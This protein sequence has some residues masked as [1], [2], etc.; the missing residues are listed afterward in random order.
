MVT[1]MKPEEL[2]FGAPASLTVEGIEVGATVD[3]PKVSVEI[4]E[5]TPDFQGARG[6]VKGTKAI[7]KVLL[8]VA[9]RINQ[10]TATKLGWAW[11]G[12][13]ATS[14]AAVGKPLAGGLDTTLAAD[15]ALGATNIKVTAV[16]NAAVDD[17]IRLGPANPT[18]ANSEVVRITTVGT[19]GGAGTG[20]DIVNDQPGGL[21]L[22]HANAEEVKEVF[23]TTVV[24]DAAAGATNVKVVAVGGLIV[25]GIVRFGDYGEYQARTLTA[26]GTAGAGG[27]GLSFAEPLTRALDAGDWA[28]ETTGLGRTTIGWTPG[29]VPSSAYRDVILKGVGLDGLGLEVQLDD[30]VSSINAE[31]EFG[32]AAISGLPVEMVAQYDPLA[33]TVLPGRI[34]IG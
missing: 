8:K 27:T 33:P 17:F 26:V 9:F 22:D 10:L 1:T 30:A 28:M 19:A 4:T 23:G 32:D 12:S 25:G 15:P 20:L 21:R 2:F 6:P 7:T 3:A 24:T 14:S 31:I 13:T 16:T 29:R 5:Y 11:P 34:I 18:E